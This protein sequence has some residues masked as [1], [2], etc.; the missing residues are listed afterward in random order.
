MYVAPAAR[1]APASAEAHKN[2]KAVG[3]QR[4]TA[5]TTL[6]KDDST[7]AVQ[8]HAEHIEPKLIDED[9]AA[10]ESASSALIPPSP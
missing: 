4:R 8:A 9:T 1:V 3:K 6:E 5:G 2:Y 7:P 10:E